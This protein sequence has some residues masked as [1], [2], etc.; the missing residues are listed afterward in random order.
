MSDI[1]LPYFLALPGTP[2]P[3]PGVVV[4]HEGNGISPQLLRVCERLA[5]QGF[6]AVAPDLYFR[7][8]GSEAK[9][10]GELMQE[11]APEQ[12]VA[13][14]ES[15]ADT[16]RAAGARR[17][18]VTG[19]CMGGRYTWL[20]AVGGHRFSAAVGFYGGGI[21]QDLREPRCP[22]LLFF[23]GRDEFIPSSDI[24]RVVAHHPATVVYP[25]AGHGFMR[26]GSDSYHQAAA[27]DAWER[28]LSFFREHLST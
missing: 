10:F 16:L 18:G 15:A 14:I 4:V 26:D 22:T 12:A 25:E 27:A 24:A 13:D 9:G 17:V 21:A 28:A 11:M 2:A 5:A 8:G 19:F 1:A 20:A 7:S 6:A 23:G 3:W